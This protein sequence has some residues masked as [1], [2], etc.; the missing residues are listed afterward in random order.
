MTYG[1]FRRSFPGDLFRPG[2]DD[3]SGQF[4]GAWERTPAQV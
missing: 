1:R 4:A 2:D 3:Y